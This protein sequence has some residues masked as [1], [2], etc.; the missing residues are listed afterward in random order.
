[1]FFTPSSTIG[2]AHS[3]GRSPADSMVP[4]NNHSAN[5]MIVALLFRISMSK[6]QHQQYHA[7]T[8]K[9]P[10]IGR[11]GTNPALVPWYEPRRKADQPVGRIH[12]EP[13]PV[14]DDPEQR[15]G[16]ENAQLDVP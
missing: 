2:C 12:H 14:L 5:K 16:T 3:S 11:H 15:K 13:K 6:R 4:H 10:V 7:D 9:R 8:A 1:M